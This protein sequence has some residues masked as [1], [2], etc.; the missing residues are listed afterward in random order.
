VPFKI[1]TE[2]DYLQAHITVLGSRPGAPV[3]DRVKERVASVMKKWM[4]WDKPEH[5]RL[6]DS[7]SR[8]PAKKNYKF[9]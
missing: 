8:G 9:F 5:S 3:L 7:L 2:A 6:A 1:C 4:E